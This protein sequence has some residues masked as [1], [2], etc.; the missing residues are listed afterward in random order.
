MS[1]GPRHCTPG[2]G[3][4]ARR[5]ARRPAALPC[6]PSPKR[7]RRPSSRGTGITGPYAKRRDR[8]VRA[9]LGRRGVK[10]RTYKDRV[11]FEGREVRT[12]QGGAYTV[13]TPYR[14]AWRRRY[15]AEPPGYSPPP[16]L[17]PGIAEAPAPA[18]AWTGG[19]RLAP[20]GAGAS[21]V[22]ASEA[23]PADTAA[24]PARRGEAGARTAGHVSWRRGASLPPR[25]GSAR[26]PG[27]VRA[28]A[29]LA[30]RRGLRA[31]VRARRALSGQG[32]AGGRAGGRGVD[33]RAGVAG[34]LPC[35]P[36]RAPAGAGRGV[37]GG[38]RHPRM[39]RRSRAP[40]GLAGGEDGIPDGGRG[41][42]AARGDRLDAQP[43]AHGRRE[44]SHQGPAH[45]LARGRTL[46]HAPPRGRRP[47]QQQRRL[48]VG[49]LDRHGRPAVFPGLQPDPAGR[50]LRIP[51]GSTSGGGSRSSRGCRARRR[52]GRGRRRPSERR[53]IRRPSSIMGASGRSPSRATARSASG[54]ADD[55]G[56]RPP[57]AASPSRP[58]LRQAAPALRSRGVVRWRSRTAAS[59]GGLRRPR[60]SHRR[61]ERLRTGSPHRAR[62][63]AG[64][65]RRRC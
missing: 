45:R 25:S 23:A 55:G 17:P 6:R 56:A 57:P 19:T 24:I 41:D 59:R 4:R 65:G 10:V 49:G 38:L 50:T 37:S 5:P 47:R 28:L 8:E 21:A 12:A 33:R 63:A 31:R 30:V 48:A 54:A 46:V 36:R 53:T 58:S 29:V 7:A 39:G 60:A 13:Y 42:A 2:R 15:R 34:V 32:R 62:A 1:R 61:R 43:R 51:R 11:V 26:G 27:H 16:R 20:L 52:T 3:L 64:P 44:L 18:H 22:A 9:A 14:R 40:S 35:G